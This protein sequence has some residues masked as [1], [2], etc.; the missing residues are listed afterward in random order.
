[1]KSC[2][3]CRNSTSPVTALCRFRNGK[4][5]QIS[6]LNLTKNKNRDDD[7]IFQDVAEDCVR[8]RLNREQVLRGLNC[9]R[10]T[11]EFL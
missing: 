1:M 8:F 9:K 6:Q 4:Q 3:F 7:E 10:L 2:F 5:E 11:E